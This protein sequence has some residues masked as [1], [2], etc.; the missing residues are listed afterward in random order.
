MF[1]EALTRIFVYGTLRKGQFNHNHFLS[2]AVLIG[3][4][5]VPDMALVSMGPFPAAVPA[6]K[7]DEDK[8]QWVVVGEVYDVSDAE[9]RAIDRLEGIDSKF[10]MRRTVETEF[11]ECVMYVL[12]PEAFRTRFGISR[13]PHLYLGG[14]FFSKDNLYEVG[15]EDWEDVFDEVY[16]VAAKLVQPPLILPETKALPPPEPEKPKVYRAYLGPGVIMAPM[17]EAE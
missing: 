8:Q 17:R 14:D 3:S 2:D 12:H 6:M 7:Y 11:G 16:L 15:P 9:L 4:T 10:Y 5:V 1:K 13:P